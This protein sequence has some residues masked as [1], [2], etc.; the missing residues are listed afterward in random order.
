MSTQRQKRVG[1]EIKK[2]ISERLIKGLRNPLPGFVTIRDVEVNRDFTRADVYFSVI[3]S[4]DDREGASKV[5]TRA[6]GFLRRE[7][8][9]GL[10]LRN[11]PE[12]F[13]SHDAS[14]ERAAVLH[15]VI[16]DLDIPDE[17]PES[18]A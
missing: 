17:E 15:K 13:F 7:V 9:K 4:D 2:I 14:G 12:L 11:T 16:D 18:D 6:A 8:G 1:D 5:L 3:G 10:R